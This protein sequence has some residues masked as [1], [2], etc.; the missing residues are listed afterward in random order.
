MPYYKK[1]NL[2]G[3]GSKIE[4][5]EPDPREKLRLREGY[6]DIFVLQ[7]KRDSDLAET[8]TKAGEERA[9]TP[10][11]VIDTEDVLTMRREQERIWGPVMAEYFQSFGLPAFRRR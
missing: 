11:A 1:T 4:Y 7:E 10:E 8:A 3:E 5:I 6:P 2:W 9:E